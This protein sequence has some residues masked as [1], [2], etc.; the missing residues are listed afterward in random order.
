MATMADLIQRLRVRVQDLAAINELLD[1]TAELGNP[2]YEEALQSALDDYNEESP[3]SS[4]TSPTEITHRGTLLDLATYRA[5][6]MA[7]LKLDRN[8]VPYSDGG[9]SVDESARVTKLLQ[10]A[11]SIRSDALRRLREI[12][13]AEAINSGF[14]GGGFTPFW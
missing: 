12:K 10:V 1:F 3:C 9:L 5:L 7:A 6:M 11:N 4:Y 2:D 8:S 13:A 14:S